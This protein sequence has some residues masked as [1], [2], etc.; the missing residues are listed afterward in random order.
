MNKK[1]TKSVFSSVAFFFSLNIFQGRHHGMA[2]HTVA[3]AGSDGDVDR[4]IFF[5]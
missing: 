1:E 2:Q 4:L 3:M 5:C